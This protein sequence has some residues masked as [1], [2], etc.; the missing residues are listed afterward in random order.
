MVKNAGT[1]LLQ[2]MAA[3][4]GPDD[5][6]IVSF[7]PGAIFTSAARGAGYDKTAMNWDD[8]ECFPVA[9]CLLFLNLSDKLTEYLP[10]NYAVWAASQE[11]KFLHGRFTWAAWDVEELAKGE[12]RSSLDSNPNLLKIG[13]LGL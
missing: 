10:G 6:Q 2:Q 5:M 11:A 13:V 8:G 3:D 9:C 12:K 1:L 4:I 7:H